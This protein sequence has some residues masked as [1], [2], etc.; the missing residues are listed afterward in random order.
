[1][2]INRK[3]LAL[4][5]VPVVIYAL[6]YLSGDVLF[7]FLCF[8]KENKQANV[9]ILEGWLDKDELNYAEE[10]FIE[11]D[12]N[13]IVT[14]GIKMPEFFRLWRNGDVV[15][16][17]DYKSSTS[18]SVNIII[19]AFGERVRQENAKF[20][21]FANDKL[22]GSRYATT[23]PLKYCFK[24]SEKEIDSV[25][26]RFHND[27]VF[28]NEDRNLLISYV[29]I[30]DHTWPINRDNVCYYVHSHSGTV[31]YHLAQTKANRIKKDL[32]YMGIEEQNILSVSINEFE[33]S[34]TYENAQIT[35]S[36]MD[37]L[38]GKRNYSVIII[39]RYPHT[40]RTYTAFLKCIK[41]KNKVGIT[42]LEVY[43]NDKLLNRRLNNLREL[44][45]IVYIKFQIN[46]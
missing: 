3:H 22:L 20:S 45:G 7:N 29:S 25:T 41:N 28:K 24:T 30:N 13:I 46:K 21:V 33:S 34:K 38:F 32:I 44:F 16:Q 23:K 11:G 43:K 15:V 31:K 37:S 5:I 40:R 1:M 8:K 6:W 42:A 14:T 17:T 35:V 39:S 2:K 26:I 36:K 27:K 10:L 19:E 9:L 12:Y 4:L 18:D